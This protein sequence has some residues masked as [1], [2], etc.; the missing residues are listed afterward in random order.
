MALLIFPSNLANSSLNPGFIQFQYYTRGS[1]MKTSADDTICLCMPDATSQPSTVSWDNEKFGFVGKSFTDTMQ[2]LGKDG[3]GV[4]AADMN[5]I[6]EGAKSKV[7]TQG[8]FNIAEAAINAIGGKVSAEGL[9]GEIA[10]KVPNPYL[11]AVFR[12]VDFRTFTFTFKFAPMS[13]SDCE[14]IDNIIRTMRANSLPEYLDNAVY[15]SYPK[16]CSISYHWKGQ[17]NEWLNRFKRAV[18]TGVDVDYAPNGT[19]STLR[20]GFP[21]QI[22]VSTKWT[23]VEIVTRQDVME[24]F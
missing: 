9:M 3:S 4:T 6:V 24:G 16:E 15:L 13:E 23:E 12:G 11:T 22:I 1:Y 20:N 21:T 5:A 17:S 2:K 7:V 18:C 19:F 14:L 8:A 10:G